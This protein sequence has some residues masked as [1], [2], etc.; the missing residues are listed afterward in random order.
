[1]R[2]YENLI[3]RE[4]E[5]YQLALMEAVSFSFFSLKKEKIQVH[6]RNMIDRKSREFRS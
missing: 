1:L 3:S 2:A 6:S 5:I 4:A